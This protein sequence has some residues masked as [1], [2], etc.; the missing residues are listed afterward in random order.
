M[1][2]KRPNWIGFSSHKKLKSSALVFGVTYSILYFLRY[3]Q[4]IAFIKKSNL[5]TLQMLMTARNSNLII[6]WQLWTDLTLVT[7]YSQ[8]NKWLVC[9]ERKLGVFPLLKSQD[10]TVWYVMTGCIVFV[11]F[12]YIAAI[13]IFFFIVIYFLDMRLKAK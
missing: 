3:G 13:L 2:L 11:Q 4:R 12:S 10:I 5:Q 7:L 6:T 1:I 8:S 9:I